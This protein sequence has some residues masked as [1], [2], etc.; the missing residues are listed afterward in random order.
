[1]PTA[2]MWCTGTSSQRTSCSPAGRR[3][4]RISAFREALTQT[5]APPSLTRQAAR[6]AVFVA[7]GVAA[8][9]AGYVLLTRRPGSSGDPARSIAV[10]PFVNIGADPNNEPF[11][12]GMSEELITALAKVEGLR[13]T[14]RTS[15]F[16]FKG[17]E[18]D[19]REI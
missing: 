5:G 4:S 15:A 7:A 1:M 10:L 18:V 17:K 9:V 12:D 19:V 2:T 13:V 14:A 6:P 16:S 8:L 11:S 3:S